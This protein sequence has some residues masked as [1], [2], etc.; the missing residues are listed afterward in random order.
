ML[1]VLLDPDKRSDLE[2][3]AANIVV[4]GIDLVLVGGSGYDKPIDEYIVRLRELLTKDGCCSCPIVLFPG[5]IRQFSDK[6]DALLFLS[7]LSCNDSAWLVG[8]HIEVARAV[9]ESGIES[10]PMGYIL[11]DGGKQ[12][13]VARVTG[14][15]PLKDIDKICSTAVAG[16]L[17][18]KKIIYL[19]AG[20]GAAKPVSAEIISAVKE[21]I[22]GVNRQEVVLIVGGGICTVEQMQTAYKAGADLVVVGNHFEMQP[23]DIVLFGAK[24]KNKR[25]LR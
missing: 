15:A 21:A 13:A 8:K 7:L 5:D 16:V 2:H 18:G 4:G 6:A 25:P 12:T 23:D 9:A 3:V 20:S 24:N 19:E 1:A 22:D 14:S 17:L 11:V 10:I